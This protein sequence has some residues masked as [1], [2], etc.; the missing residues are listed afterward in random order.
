MMLDCSSQILSRLFGK[1]ALQQESGALRKIPLAARPTG[2]DAV[3]RRAQAFAQFLGDPRKLAYP[4]V[5]GE[6]H[7]RG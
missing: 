3:L 7:M 2:Q 6:S 1:P 5:V 4:A